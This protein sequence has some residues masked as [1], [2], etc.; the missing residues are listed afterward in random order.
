VLNVLMAL[1]MV[2][3]EPTAL[4]HPITADRSVWVRSRAGGLLRFHISPGQLVHKGD[5]VAT[6]DN[7]FVHKSVTFKAPVTGVVIG[8]RTL[9]AVKPGDPICNIAIPEQSLSKV[10]EAV[11]SDSGSLHHRVQTSRT[12]SVEV[13]EPPSQRGAY[14]D[15]DDSYASEP[16]PD[17][18]G[19]YE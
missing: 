8:L 13:S 12:S 17:T 11:D 18:P 19:E 6:V 14:A 4:A 5:A 9:P 16:S 1:G 2:E 10:R 7:L 3:G 15:I